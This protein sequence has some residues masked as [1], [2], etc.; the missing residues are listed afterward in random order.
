M[1]RNI[2]WIL[3]LIVDVAYVA[4][5][6]MHLLHGVRVYGKHHRC[7]GLPPW[8]SLGMVDFA[9]WQHNRIGIGHE[10]RLDRERHRAV[11]THRIPRP[12]PRLQRSRDHSSFPGRWAA[13]STNGLIRKGCVEWFFS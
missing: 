6:A 4:W 9:R 13:T 10:I 11:R 7:H 12:R 5:G 3:I 2:A 1:K 8:R